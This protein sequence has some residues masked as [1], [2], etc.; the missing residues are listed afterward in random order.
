MDPEPDCGSVGPCDALGGSGPYTLILTVWDFLGRER[1]SN[2]DLE[3]MMLITSLSSELTQ[4][5]LSCTVGKRIGNREGLEV[6]NIAF[7]LEVCVINFR[8]WSK[9]V[10]WTIL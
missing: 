3:D 9:E 5:L 10:M 1:L 7:H 4:V 8:N 6:L 2:L